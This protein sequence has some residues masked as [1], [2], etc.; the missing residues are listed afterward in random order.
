[1]AILLHATLHEEMALHR[2]YCAQLGIPAAQLEQEVMAPTTRGYTD[3]LL[4]T[5]TLG[6]FAELVAYLAERLPHFMVPRF[7]ELVDG[8]PKTPSMRVQKHVLRERGNSERTW[9]REVAGLRVTRDG[10]VRR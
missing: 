3:F 4:R 5:A 1:M 7:Y 6:D 8:L 10:L 9:D 2:A